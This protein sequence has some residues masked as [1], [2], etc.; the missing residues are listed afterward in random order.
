MARTYEPKEIPP[1]YILEGTPTANEAAGI[2]GPSKTPT[3]DEELVNAA[4]TG[5]AA[6]GGQTAAGSTTGAAAA[7]SPNSPAVTN[8]T[9][10]GPAAKST[11]KP[12]RSMLGTVTE[13]K[14]GLMVS[15]DEKGS[16]S[17]HMASK[18]GSQAYAKK[19]VRDKVTSPVQKKVD[20]VKA[21][22]DK[23][24][25]K[26][27]K[28]EQQTKDR[29][30][31]TGDEL[32]KSVIDQV[33]DKIVSL[34]VIPEPVLLVTLKG[35][36]GM[37]GRPDYSNNYSIKEMLKK[38]YSMIIKWMAEDFGY[39]VVSGKQASVF[40][41]AASY[42]ATKCAIYVLKR[43]YDVMGQKWYQLNRYAEIKRIICGGKMNFS[44][45]E[46]LSIMN[47]GLKQNSPA[48]TVV[49]GG[50]GE[51]GCEEFGKKYMFTTSDVNKFLPEKKS[52]SGLYWETYPSTMD[53]VNLMKKML[54]DGEI[55]D[56]VR[57]L[58]L[59]G[60]DLTGKPADILKLY[61][62]KI[63][64][65][66]D[67]YAR[68]LGDGIVPAMWYHDSDF[69]GPDDVICLEV[70]L[71]P[72]KK[73]DSTPGSAPPPGYVPPAA[74]TS[75][76]LNIERLII[77]TDESKIQPAPE[78]VIYVGMG[79]IPKA[80]LVEGKKVSYKGKIGVWYKTMPSDIMKMQPTRVLYTDT[81]TGGE[82]QSYPK[83]SENNPNMMLFKLPAFGK[84]SKIP[85][86][87]FILTNVLLPRE[88]FKNDETEMV[89][90]VIHKR[91]YNNLI[92]FNPVVKIISDAVGSYL[93]E[94]GIDKIIDKVLHREQLMYDYLK[95]LK[96]E[97]LL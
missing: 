46:M 10:P 51:K 86:E 67:V 74:P 40:S 2:P 54:G 64:K 45:N 66:Q 3:P 96:K 44:M 52:K 73:S 70:L 12:T 19:S 16:T 53:H 81:E 17:A 65:E 27:N 42:G 60:L 88:M 49:Y 38:D 23:T 18:E 69:N 63:S 30:L 90:K 7:A 28:L 5:D 6:A 84:E 97:K 14:D 48:E 72:A 1:A 71:Q 59:N 39:S 15:T 4:G 24:K 32:V 8:P 79:V 25:D 57:D 94:T 68:E 13:R 78:P 41:S 87:N 34:M 33:I 89:H 35:L 21:I 20:A 95:M 82:Y 55:P 80:E 37:G 36:A 62:L 43:K 22:P 77:T 31:K 76:I 26:M 83:R 11:A 93:K 56:Y 9:G 61:G 91:I 58:S 50:F 75:P 29:L 85:P 92:V 47:D